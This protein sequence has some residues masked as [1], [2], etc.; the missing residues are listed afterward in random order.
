V[1]CRSTFRRVSVTKLSSMDF[2]ASGS[3]PEKAVRAEKFK[4]EE[5]ASS[6]GGSAAYFGQPVNPAYCTDTMRC[7]F[8]FPI[9]KV[10]IDKDDPNAGGKGAGHIQFRV[11]GFL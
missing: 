1:F 8:S 2:A 9:V 7:Y 11:P 6:K 10:L 3:S 5:G 4:V